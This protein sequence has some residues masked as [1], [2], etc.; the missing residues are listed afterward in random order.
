MLPMSIHQERLSTDQ[1][2]IIQNELS[3]VDHINANFQT[4]W[5][6]P[7]DAYEF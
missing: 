4:K 7:P 6:P 5:Q 1:S 3:G 2:G